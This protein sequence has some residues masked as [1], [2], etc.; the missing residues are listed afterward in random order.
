MSLK[1]FGVGNPLLSDAGAGVAVARLLDPPPDA[2]IFQGEIF[3]EDCLL[4][5]EKGDAVIILDAVQF[6]APAGMVISIPFEDCKRYCPPKAFCHEVSLLHALLYGNLQVP[7]YLIG[8]QVSEIAFH[9]GLSPILSEMLPDI[10][11]RVNQAVAAILR[12]SD[13]MGAYGASSTPLISSEAMRN[14]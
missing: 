7:G 4:S 1:I 11:R 12:G 8:I 3:V 6:D 5:I 14:A 2:R 10:V 13:A 9:E